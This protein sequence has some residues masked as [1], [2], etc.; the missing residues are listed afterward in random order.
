MLNRLR[1][2]FCHLLNVQRINDV[3]RTEIDTEEPLMP[4]QSAFEVVM[5]IE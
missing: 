1:N 2:H 4:E 5:A 3:R